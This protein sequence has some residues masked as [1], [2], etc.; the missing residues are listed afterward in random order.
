MVETCSKRMMAEIQGD[1]VVFLI[2]MRMNK[3]WKINK[4][5]PIV[6]AMRRMLKELENSPP[7]TGYLGHTVLGLGAIVQYWRS[8]GHL[9]DYSRSPN[10]LHWPAW[11][12]FNRRMKECRCDVGIWHETYQIRSGEF[13]TIYSGMP[14]HG[15]AKAAGAALITPS[16]DRARQRINLRP[17]TTL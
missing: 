13:E 1:F 11:L 2:G 8:F 3:P 9:E 5:W 10:H 6:R 16:S 12:E 4:W 17:E 14:L 7:E 15:L